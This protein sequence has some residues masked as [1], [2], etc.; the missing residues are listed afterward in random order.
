M[1]YLFLLLF[2]TML[3]CTQHY[4]APRTVCTCE[5]SEKVAA[6]VERSIKNANNMSDEEMEDVVIQLER[7][8]RN[9]Y[10]RDKMMWIEYE[11]MGYPNVDWTK[12]KL[13]S[14]ESLY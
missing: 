5:Q 1:K 3:S 9:T 7:T 10:C 4:Q 2:L 12:S 8:Y 13:D 14:C 11:F 6:A